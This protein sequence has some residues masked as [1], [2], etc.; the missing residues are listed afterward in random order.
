MT[1][2]G[3]LEMVSFEKLQSRARGP[4]AWGAAGDIVHLDGELLQMIDTS[5]QL[6]YQHG[7]VRH[8]LHVWQLLRFCTF[9]ASHEDGEESAD[10]GHS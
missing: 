10:S 1:L 5:V 6:G 3:T 8:C 7:E 4:D 9:R 2:Q